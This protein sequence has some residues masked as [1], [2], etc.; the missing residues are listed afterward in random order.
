MIDDRRVPAGQLCDGGTVMRC[1]RRSPFPAVLTVAAL[2]LLTASCGG[3]GG[4][5]AGTSSTNGATSAPTTSPAGSGPAGS[6]PATSGPA[7]STTA[8]VEKE[9]LDLDR[10]TFG[11]PTT[12]DNRWFPLTPGVRLTFTGSVLVDGEKLGHEFV[13][14]V[15]DMVKEIDGVRS[16]VL[17]ELDYTDGELKEAELAFFAQDDAGVVWQLGEYPEEYENGRFDAAP[18]WISGQK[19]AKAGIAMKADPQLGSPSYPQ[20]WGPAVDW[21]DR[22]RLI[23]TGQKTCVPAGCYPGVIVTEEF[24]RSDPDAFQLKFYAPGVGLVRVGWAGTKELDHEVLQLTRATTLSPAA[25][26]AVRK[27]ALALEKHG[28]QVS[29]DVYAKTAPMERATGS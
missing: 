19:G 8:E 9:T 5:S 10:G 21:K 20:G 23:K 11:R 27:A 3:A 14:T 7:T 25:L 4:T 13:F 28:Y 15:T 29:K 17:Y 26:A 1:P 24:A 16:V 6:G 2:C 22:A 12:V 18:S